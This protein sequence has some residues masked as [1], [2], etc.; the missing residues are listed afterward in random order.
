MDY[1]SLMIFLCRGM[2]LQ[3]LAF[4]TY[5]TGTPWLACC[6]EE[7]LWCGPLAVISLPPSSFSSCC[8]FA[9]YS[10]FS[11]RNSIVSTRLA[12]S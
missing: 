9:Q 4:T 1:S 12:F 7:L 8:S 11:N 10:S 2:R 3:R 6:K 5:L